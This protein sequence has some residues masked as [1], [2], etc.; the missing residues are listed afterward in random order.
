MDKQSF[1]TMMNAY[2]RDLFQ[3]KSVKQINYAIMMMSLSMSNR[4]LT[5]GQMRQ[6][7]ALS[8]A[9]DIKLERLYSQEEEAKERLSSAME[10][11]PVE[12]ISLEDFLNEE[13]D[14]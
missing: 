12:K 10:K 14:Y 6:Y 11:L 2:E 9:Y 1:D 4:D 7:E 5:Y 3:A 8:N 13:D